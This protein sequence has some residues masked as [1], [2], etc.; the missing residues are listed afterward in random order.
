MLNLFKILTVAIL[1]VTLFSACTDN[2]AT[3]I[4]YDMEKMAFMA[5]KLAKQLNIQPELTTEKD[6]LQLKTAYNDILDYYFENI[7][8]TQIS[9]DTLIQS[10]MSRIALA[11]QLQLAY[12]YQSNKQID[13]LITAFRRI[14]T[15]IPAGRDDIIAAKL[16]LASTFK[17]LR[18]FDST[19]AIYDDI[20]KF[21]YPPIDYYNRIN[22]DVMSIPVDNIRISRGFENAQRTDKFI[23]DAIEY[24]QKIKIDFPQNDALVRSANVFLSRTYALT[25]QWDKT[26][27]QLNEIKDST[28]QIDITAQILMAN[29]YNGPINNSDKAVELYQSILDRRP[30]SIIMAQVVL[31]IGK[32]HCSQGNYRE[33]RQYFIDLKN[34]YRQFPQILAHA[35]MIYAQSFHAEGDRERALSEF[36][37]LMDNYPFTEDAY[38]AA[39]YIP[40]YFMQD[41]DVELAQLWYDRAIEFYQKAADSKQ[42]QQAGLIAYTYMADVYRHTENHQKALEILDK[43]YTLAPGTRY[44][45]RALYNSAGIAL[46]NL[47]DTTRAQNYLDIL[48]REFGT[49]DSTSLYNDENRDLLLK[50]LQ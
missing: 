6:K 17:S 39:R 49:I 40:E 8:V 28:G 30:D 3:K 4:R 37:W 43:I 33:G 20:M 14:G 19:M 34:R 26:I 44:A 31:D 15:E 46:K 22:N 11:S 45:A 16:G 7:D 32:V 36:Q 35:Q 48:N 42:R 10:Q 9:A 5:G 2:S 1:G 24:Y 29:I 27:S 41:G 47:N 25:E 23:N 12:Y 21:Y 18:I 13:S 38:K 50:S